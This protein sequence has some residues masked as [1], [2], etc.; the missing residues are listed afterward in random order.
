MRYGSCLYVIAAESKEEAIKIAH[1]AAPR[2]GDFVC[3]SGDFSECDVDRELAGNYIGE[4][5]IVCSR[6]WEE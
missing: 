2:V 1:D 5:G 4:R 3:D 6:R